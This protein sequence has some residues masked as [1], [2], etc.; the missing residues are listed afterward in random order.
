MRIT[1]AGGGSRLPATANKFVHI[2]WKNLICDNVAAG[3]FCAWPRGGGA[4]DVRPSPVVSVKATL[5]P[6]AVR[7]RTLIVSMRKKMVATSQ[8]RVMPSGAQCAPLRG[9]APRSW[10]RPASL[11][12][13][14][15]FTFSRPT[16]L[17]GNSPSRAL[18][19]CAAMAYGV[20]ANPLPVVMAIGRQLESVTYSCARSVP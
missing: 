6:G 11:A 7:A 14:R 12:A 15:Q 19:N 8:A 3:G 2:L 9:G 1:P 16:K 18:R 4:G 13:A 20:A 5:R 10:P 17:H